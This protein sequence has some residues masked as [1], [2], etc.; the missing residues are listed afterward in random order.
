MKKLFLSLC[1]FLL[2]FS[3]G[4]VA[5]YLLVTTGPIDFVPEYPTFD[6]STQAKLDDLHRAYKARPGI[7]PSLVDT[8][9]GV[10]TPVIDGDV[11][12][13]LDVVVSLYQASKPLEQ[14]AYENAFFELT[15]QV[16]ALSEDE[17]AGQEPP[18]KLGFDELNTLLEALFDADMVNATKLSIK[19]LSI[20]SALKRYNTLWWDDAIQHEIPEE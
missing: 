14:R 17:R 11:S 9:S 10:W 18:V 12:S 3:S 2:V 16:L 8:L 20:D 6:G 7:F 15:E 5:R 4:A 1:L 19:L 13:A